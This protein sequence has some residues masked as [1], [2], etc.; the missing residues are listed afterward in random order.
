MCTRGFFP[1]GKVA[2]ACSWPLT[3]IWCRGQECV[4]LYLHYT[5]MA[6]C[7]AKPQGQVYLYLLC[8]ATYLKYVASFYM[9][10]G[11]LWYCL[12]HLLSLK[13]KLES[14]LPVAIVTHLPCNRTVTCFEWRKG[15]YFDLSRWWRRIYTDR[16][17]MTIVPSSNDDGLDND[18]DSNDNSRVIMNES[19]R[20]ACHANETLNSSLARRLYI[21]P[22]HP[23][24]H[25]HHL[26]A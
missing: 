24:T 15:C 23:L 20:H 4:E 1:W 16:V 10:L 18:Y 11:L 14:A 6:W 22:P 26:T 5:F 2:R 8:L 19:G 3:L 7:S 12:G 21:N 13:T 17:E 9:E 25:V